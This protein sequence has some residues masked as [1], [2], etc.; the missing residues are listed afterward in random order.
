MSC[1]HSE[2]KFVLRIEDEHID[3]ELTVTM[4]RQ[5]NGYATA[6]TTSDIPK[7]PALTPERLS[8]VIAEMFV[9][10]GAAA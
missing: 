6:T 1:W 3:G 5:L 8:A 4:T 10:E 9:L 2:M 7:E